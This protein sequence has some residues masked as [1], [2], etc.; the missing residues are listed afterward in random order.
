MSRLF[1]FYSQAFS[2]GLKVGEEISNGSIQ[3]KS[4]KSVQ[5]V[6]L[7][8][9]SQ[10]EEMARR[11]SK[12]DNDVKDASFAVIAWLDEVMAK[13]S[14][15]LGFASTPLQVLRFN[16][17]NAGEEF[18]D[19]L[20]RLTADQDE[21]REV[22]Y[23]ALVL[24]FLGKYMLN[25]A[26][27]E[28][29]RLIDSQARQLPVKPVGIG[30]VLEAKITAQPYQLEAPG[31]RRVPANWNKAALT[32][33]LLLAVLV[34][35]GVFAYFKLKEPAPAPAIVVAPVV[36][37]VSAELKKRV[38]L[39][40][41]ARLEPTVVG[42][43]I[44]L[45]GHIS[46]DGDLARLKSE[47]LAIKGVIGVNA[48][49]VTVYPKPYCEIASALVPYTDN[50]ASG[51]KIQLKGGALV[52]REGEKLVVDIIPGNFT[53][54]VYAAVVDP[55]G[56]VAHFLPNPGEPQNAVVAGQPLVAGTKG[57]RGAGWEVS[58]P[59]G[60]HMMIVIAKSQPLYQ[61]KR[62]SV[63][64]YK[65]YLSMVQAGLAS[66]APDDRTVVYYRLVELAK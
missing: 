23:L 47:V 29:A 49:A 9:V 38:A 39:F 26:S 42:G 11:A 53:G 8:C 63:E 13:D 10:A 30:S 7:D 22:F 43:Q 55:D 25:P 48:D 62:E 34:P 27:A 32:V 18:F 60:K 35:L 15:W 54:L 51:L 36:V 24:G 66:K 46:S 57:L 2:E 59:F 14:D 3:T 16:N 33:G 20:G 44:T 4:V 40:E 21:V 19:H 52:A 6:F 37:D 65:D 41:C 64:N 58:A 45:K 12:R 5:S 28:L 56:N 61:G 50:G 31:S 17:Y 1:D